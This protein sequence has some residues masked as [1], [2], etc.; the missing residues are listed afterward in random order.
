M[1]AAG[2][3]APSEG[4]QQH[5]GGGVAKA[6]PAQQHGSTGAALTKQRIG[7]PATQAPRLHTRNLPFFAHLLFSGALEKMAARAES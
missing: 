5:A 7:W 4:V 1:Q 2:W 3:Q 6:A